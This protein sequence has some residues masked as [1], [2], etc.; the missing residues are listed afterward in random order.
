MTRMEGIIIIHDFEELV[1]L[2]KTKYR[3]E[4]TQM[5]RIDVGDIYIYN[6]IQWEE[7]VEACALLYTL[8]IKWG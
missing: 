2:L 6:E 5:T 8:Y 4:T 3:K 1:H 7:G